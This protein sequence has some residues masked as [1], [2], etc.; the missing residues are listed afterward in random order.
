M[1]FCKRD[2]VHKPCGH[3]QYQ[4]KQGLTSRYQNGETRNIIRLAAIC[5]LE[6]SFEKI[7]PQS[8]GN[9]LGGY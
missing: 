8:C 7:N 9:S 6:V 3:H 4:Y 5:D 2:A 1:L